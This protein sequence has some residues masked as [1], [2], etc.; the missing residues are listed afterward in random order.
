MNACKAQAEEILK[1]ELSY[2]WLK[3][4][5]VEAVLAFSYLIKSAVES[6]VEFMLQF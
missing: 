4:V 2:D 3:K 1:A 5:R 6:F